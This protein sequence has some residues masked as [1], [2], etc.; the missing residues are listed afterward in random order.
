M[1]KRRKTSRKK[2]AKKTAKN[3]AKKTAKKAVRPA[4]SSS[5][6]QV[7]ER[8][9][10]KQS[11]KMLDA[12]TKRYQRFVRQAAVATNDAHR[13]KYLTAALSAVA[14]AGVVANDLRRRI[15]RAPTARA[16][17]KRL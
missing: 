3:S 16:R 8:A 17:K 15:E 2:T 4:A 1:A 10:L 11:N 6:Y 13:R 5:L 14:I 12:A 7:A 9:V